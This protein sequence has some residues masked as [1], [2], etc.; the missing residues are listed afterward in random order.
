MTRALA[1]LTGAA[2]LAALLLGAYRLYGAVKAR[3][4]AQ[5]PLCMRPVQPATAFSVLVHGR[6]IRACCPRCW[7][8][9]Y[10]Q[11][12]G[13][14]EQATATDFI[15]GEPVAA[16]ACVYVEGSSVC[17]CCSPNIIAGTYEDVPA[18]KCFDRC[19][20][21]VLAFRQPGDASAF[22]ERHGGSVL[23]YAAL[24]GKAGKH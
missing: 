6:Q 18:I 4:L 24:A 23:S 22:A 3:E 17:P 12:G 2:V 9:C 20:P 16:D 8:T 1:F 15:T 19:M 10:G 21:S 11:T 13:P 7:L 5:C 14:V